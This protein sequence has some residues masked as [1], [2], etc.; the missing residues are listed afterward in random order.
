MFIDDDDE[1]YDE[2]SV[3]RLLKLADT[4]TIIAVTG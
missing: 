2:T 1:L 4:S 3:E